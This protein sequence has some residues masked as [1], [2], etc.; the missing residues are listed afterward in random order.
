MEPTWMF[1]NNELLTLMTN[2]PTIAE[3]LSGPNAEEWWKAMAKEFSTLEQMGMYK[4]TDLP[5]KRKAMGNKWVL[6]LKHN[7]NSTPI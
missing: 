5:P 2:S 1:I 7:K 3:A 4:L 6:V